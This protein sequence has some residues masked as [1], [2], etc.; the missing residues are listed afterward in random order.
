[1]ALNGTDI[2][3]VAINDGDNVTLKPSLTASSTSTSLFVRGLSSR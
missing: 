3:R 1:M 2:N